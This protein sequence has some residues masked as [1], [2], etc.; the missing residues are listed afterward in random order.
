MRVRPIVTILLC[1]LIAMWCLYPIVRDS[2][3]QSGNEISTNYTY[4]DGELAV[5]PN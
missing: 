5:A 3:L 1:V 4:V 2:Y